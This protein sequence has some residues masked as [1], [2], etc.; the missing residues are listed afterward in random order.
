MTGNKKSP[1]VVKSGL[2]QGRRLASM[3]AETL[4]E[5]LPDGRLSLGSPEGLHFF[6]VDLVQHH[7]IVGVEFHSVLLE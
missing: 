1:R 6:V 5:A 3:E 4:Q 2:D 7:W